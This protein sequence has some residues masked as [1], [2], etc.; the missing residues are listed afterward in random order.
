[1]RERTFRWAVEVAVPRRQ[2]WRYVSDTNRM[3]RLNG[4]F[5][6]VYTYEPNDGGGSTVH[7]RARV[8]GLWT[9]RWTERPTEWV[10]PDHFT[11]SREYDNGPFCRLAY[12]VEL[13][14]CAGQSD[15]TQVEH[16]ITVVPRHWLGALLAPVIFGFAAQRR[17]A[18]VLARA[19]GWATDGGYPLLGTEASRA[20]P[21][22][23]REIAAVLTGLAEELDA[24]PITESLQ[25]L[26]TTQPDSELHSLEPYMLADRWKVDRRRT[27]EVFLHATKRGLFDLEYNLICPSCRQPQQRVAA[28]AELTEASH[29][30]TCNIGFGV[31]FDRAVEVRFS[32]QPIGLGLSYATYC[33]SGPANTPHRVAAWPLGAGEEREVV[34]P[35]GQGK[36]Q[37][38]APQCGSAVF[39]DLVEETTGRSTCAEVKLTAAGIVGLPERL[40]PA[41][42]RLR[43]RNTLPIAAELIMSRTE[44]AD[45]AVTAADLTAMHEFRSLF[46]SEILAPGAEFS[47]RN[48]VFLFTDLVGSTAMYERIGDAPAFGLV[49]DH[50]DLM[51][52]ILTSH[53][54]TLVKTIGDAVMAV[55]RRP[56]D[57]LRASLEMQARIGLII[58][59]VGDPLE[60]RV[61]L[62]QGPCIVMNANDRVDYFGTTVNLAA[63]VQSLAAGGEI[64]LSPA[65]AEHSSVADLVVSM[66][67]RRQQDVELKGLS[68][69]HHVT[70][71][72]T[73]RIPPQEPP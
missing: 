8:G 71:L 3:N 27:L 72:Q 19:P 65:V 20:G 54:G 63:R 23:R 32:P 18:A 42:E 64:A 15:S 33:H 16:T 14:D 34:V 67:G 6:V 24:A 47:I 25:Q 53:D 4:L 61:G 17:T 40:K 21:R 51:V 43:V 12:R 45:A 52:E 22:Q 69:T 38:S 68:G 39:A 9:L 55:F 44:W 58:D 73:Q 41:V 66:P 35:E 28:L 10:E 31:D 7:A 48:M 2:L 5:P 11:I 36:H 37:F 59:P 50:F 49:R 62:N 56:D 57:G 29:C 70:I 60:L 46:G 1:M 30:D 13:L 26:L